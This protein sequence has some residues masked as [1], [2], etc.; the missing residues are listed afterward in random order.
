M[1]STEW[2]HAFGDEIRRFQHVEIAWLLVVVEDYLLIKL[3]DF[4]HLA[5]YLDDFFDRC[6]EL[7]GFF[8]GVVE[9]E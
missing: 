8:P 4:R 1:I 6:G 5:E 7:V 9:R 3:A 2:V